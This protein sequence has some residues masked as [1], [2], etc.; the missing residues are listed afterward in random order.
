M[1]RVSLKSLFYKKIRLKIMKNVLFKVLLV[2]LLAVVFTACND[3]NAEKKIAEL[4]SRLKELE[5]K[6][7]PGT[8]TATPASA[9]PVTQPVTDEKPEGPL[10]AFQFQ[11]T[12]HDFGT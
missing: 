5:G 9:T 11:T 3:R 8:A 2:V 10:P 4:E 12:D 1:F 6:K 7:A